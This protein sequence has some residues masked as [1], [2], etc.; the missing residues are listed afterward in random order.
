MSKIYLA[1]HEIIE[2]FPNIEALAAAEYTNYYMSQSHI[3]L[4]WADGLTGAGIKVGVCDTGVQID[5]PMYTGKI[6]AGKNFTDDGLA[7]DDISSTYYHGTAVT[8]L[9]AG[10]YMN[11]N[12]YGVA[13]DAEIVIAKVLKQKD[14][15]KATGSNSWI[16]NGIN[17][18]VEQG[19]DIINLSLGSFSNNA[20][21][22]EAVRN[23]VAQGVSVV[24]ASGNFGN[25]GNPTMYPAAYDDSISVGSMNNNYNVVDS[26]TYNTFVD[27]VAPGD[28][29][30]G[31]TLNSEYVSLWGTSFSAPL[32]SGT[33]A[34][35]KQK[36][37]RDFGRKPNE[38]ELFAMLIKQTR[39]LPS[40]DRQHQGHG[41]FDASIN[42]TRRI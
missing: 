21:E 39:A 20:S 13:P 1:D 38:A 17:Y 42:K 34:L 24:C 7:E 30:Y 25:A 12:L 10:N 4:L 8:S 27:I 15:G 37:I 14:D 28:G 29:I 41:Y 26:S 18:C 23:A 5:H 3:N 22:E 9:I 32:I 31:A 33:L 6:V 36:F 19:C 2:V 40:I 35:L 11:H 16:V